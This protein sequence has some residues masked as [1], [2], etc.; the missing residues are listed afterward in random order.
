MFA[1]AVEIAGD[2]ANGR[3]TYCKSARVFH[4]EIR[5]GRDHHYLSGRAALVETYYR[6][7]PVSSQVG[8]DRIAGGRAQRVLAPVGR[9][10]AGGPVYFNSVTEKETLLNIRDSAHQGR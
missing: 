8:D 4:G 6:T 5:I 1:V 2:H 3:R 7:D 10:S 9:R